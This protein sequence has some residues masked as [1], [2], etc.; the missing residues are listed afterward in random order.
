MFLIYDLA[1]VHEL[2]FRYTHHQTPEPNG[3]HLYEKNKMALHNNQF[4]YSS[5]MANSHGDSV[6]SAFL[7]FYIGD[8]P[9]DINYR[10]LSS[11]P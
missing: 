5:H 10:S 4:D 9:Q 1:L 8:G 11:N 3:L 6:L 2:G 7:P